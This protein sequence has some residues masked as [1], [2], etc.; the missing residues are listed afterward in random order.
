MIFHF[1][2]ELLL[3]PLRKMGRMKQ[4]GKYDGRWIGDSE[5]ALYVVQVGWVFQTEKCLVVWQ[6][7]YVKSVMVSCFD[8]SSKLMMM[9]IFEFAVSFWFVERWSEKTGRAGCV[10]VGVRWKWMM[11]CGRGDVLHQL[12]FGGAR[13]E[14]FHG[15]R[16]Y[17]MMSRTDGA[18]D[19]TWVTKSMHI[20]TVT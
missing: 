4:V 3:N 12:Y 6:C 9:I 15:G 17:S 14:R 16:V 1:L 11:I 8:L 18:D 19:M 20:Q 10:S 2:V 13:Q 5:T 7:S